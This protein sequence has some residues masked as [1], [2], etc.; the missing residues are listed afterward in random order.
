MDSKTIRLAVVMAVTAVVLIVLA[1]YAVNADRI[2]E[3]RASKESTADASDTGETLPADDGTDLMVTDGS[4]RAFGEQIGN[5]TK[6]FL[7]DESFF[8]PMQDVAVIS[9]GDEEPVEMNAAVVGDSIHVTVTNTRGGIETDTA[10]QINVAGPV[11]SDEK[12]WTD[13]DRDGQIDIPIT[14]VGTYRLRML[15]IS[16][17][18]TPSQTYFVKIEK[19]EN[20]LVSYLQVN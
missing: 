8:D 3:R 5:Q 16:G 11:L 13:T 6:A 12:T 18:Q 14:G 4:F 9:D 1:V 7:Y 20:G 10:F 2:R 19:P 15:E 17:Y